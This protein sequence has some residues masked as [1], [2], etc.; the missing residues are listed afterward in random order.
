MR[1]AS[2]ELEAQLIERNVEKRNEIIAGAEE[3]AK[4]ILQAAEKECERIR[5]ES[6]KQILGIVGGELRAVRDRIIGKANIDGRKMVM[7]SREEALSSVFTEVERRLRGIAEGLDESADYG[8][9]LAK[10][11]IEAATAMGGDEF[12]ATANDRDLKHLTRHL[13][14]VK[15]RLKDALGDVRLQLDDKP[16]ETMGGV[17]VRNRDGTKTYNNTL[18]GRL[19]KVRSRVEAMVAKTLGVI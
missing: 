8:V 14:G 11:I 7:L 1:T 6:D 3:R 18:E 5:G 13:K 9:V 12:M 2:I 19:I 17:V 4:R 16:I 10:L 15:E